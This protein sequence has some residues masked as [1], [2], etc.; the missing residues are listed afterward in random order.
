MQKSSQWTESVRLVFLCIRLPDS[1]NC[2]YNFVEA[3]A[4]VELALLILETCQHFRK[5]SIALLT[6]NQCTS[7]SLNRFFYEFRKTYC[8]TLAS[9]RPL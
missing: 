4:K 3:F 6:A 7:T 5:G 9:L 8:M 1:N 2:F